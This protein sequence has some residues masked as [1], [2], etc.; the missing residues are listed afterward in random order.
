MISTFYFSNIHQSLTKK[1][2]EKLRNTP[3]S[4]SVATDFELDSKL[5]GK[6][7]KIVKKFYEIFHFIHA[8]R[9]SFPNP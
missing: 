5:S 8:E 1:S 3:E 2:P 6:E 9:R 4:F 7:K